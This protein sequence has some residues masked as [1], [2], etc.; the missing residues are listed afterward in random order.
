MHT[1]FHHKKLLTGHSNASSMKLAEATLGLSNCN[2]ASSV[3]NTVT[4]HTVEWSQTSLHPASAYQFSQP[5]SGLEKGTS[6]YHFSSLER[7]VRMPFPK[8]SS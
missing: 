3:L 4:A 8:H 6:H 1:G 5:G 7:T 2:P